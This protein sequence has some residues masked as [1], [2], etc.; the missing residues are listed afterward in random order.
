MTNILVL[1]ILSFLVFYIFTQ[2]CKIRITKEKTLRI[3]IHLQIIA[4]IINPGGRSVKQGNSQPTNKKQLLTATKGLLSKSKITLHK[5]K[6]PHPENSNT[7]VITT[8]Y[9]IIYGTVLAYL[10]SISREF[11]LDNNALT[12]F[13]DTNSF[14][15]DIT[16]K[17]GLYQ[18]TL[19]LVRLGLHMIKE[20]ISVRE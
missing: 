11:I 5:L 7:T 18:L 14:Y 12:L 9:S 2:E 15:F 13:P 17:C 4:I 8:A 20:K 3:E 19:V 1:I 16:I 6:L 10:E